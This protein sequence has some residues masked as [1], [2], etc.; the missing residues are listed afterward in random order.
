MPDFSIGIWDFDFFEPISYYYFALAVVAASMWIIWRIEKSPIGLTFHAIHWQDRL[1]E[2]SGINVRGYRTLALVLASGFAGLAGSLLAHYI[3]AISPNAYDIDKMIYVLTWAIVG[4]TATFYGPVLGCI[5]FTVINEIV[6]RELGLGQLRP[7]VY[8]L[9]LIAAVLFLPE[10][11]E[12]L[13]RKSLHRF[14]SWKQ[15]MRGVT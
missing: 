1:A 9:L 11:L 4:G 3:G 7:F 6:L 15:R 12:S 13:V 5:V 2:A 10:G 8:G 14:E